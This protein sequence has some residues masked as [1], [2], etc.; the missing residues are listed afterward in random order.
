MTTLLSP[1]IAVVL[2][3]FGAGSTL[4]QQTAKDSKP[5]TPAEG[6]AQ[7]VLDA[8]NGIGDKLIEMAQD[9]PAEKYD[10]R[11]T[12]GVRTFAEVLI[13]LVG[14][15]YIFTDTAQ[16]KPLRPH[17][18]KRKDYPTKASIM[19]ALKVAYRE[20]TD[21][22]KAKGDKGMSQMVYQDFGNQMV[23]VYDVGYSSAMHASE[24]YG[25]L[26]VYFRLN[27]IVPPESRKN[28]QQQQKND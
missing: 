1:L 23:H 27:G 22:I 2:L 11:P 14:T 3:A 9:F 17:D 4:A 21:V 18:L 10:F 15:S 12:P 5:P 16:G 19:A 6:L 26:V 13:H 8:W 28:T 25:Q 7:E 20:G 24:H